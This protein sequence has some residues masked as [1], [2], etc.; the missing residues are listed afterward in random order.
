M[1]KTVAGIRKKNFKK[2]L[3]SDVARKARAPTSWT[4]WAATPPIPRY[5]CSGSALVGMVACSLL[6]A[7]YAAAPSKSESKPV[8]CLVD[9]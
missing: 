4:E 6:L 9:S 1:I 2:G 3:F 5:V 7:A 8:L